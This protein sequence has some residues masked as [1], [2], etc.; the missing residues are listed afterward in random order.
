MARTPWTIPRL[1]ILAKRVTVNKNCFL[2]F[3]SHVT[4]LVR[5]YLWPYVCNF[6][7]RIC[8]ALVSSRPS[9]NIKWGRRDGKKTPYHKN[10]F[11]VTSHRLNWLRRKDIRRTADRTNEVT[12]CGL[13][14]LSAAL[15]RSWKTQ[16]STA[17][18]RPLTGKSLNQAVTGDTVNFAE[19]P[20]V[21][22]PE[23]VLFSKVIIS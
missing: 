20:H 3:Y 17:I 2:K 19:G 14:V 1:W 23:A 4:V 16:R 10:G 9:I 12:E 11:M 15:A 22:G 13:G 21:R 7:T 18:R 6:W 8:V 5:Q